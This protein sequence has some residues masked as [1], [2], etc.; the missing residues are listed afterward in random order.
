MQSWLELSYEIS[1]LILE[2]HRRWFWDVPEDWRSLQS[3]EGSWTEENLWQPAVSMQFRFS[4]N[5]W[6]SEKFGVSVRCSERVLFSHLQMWWILYP[7]GRLQGRWI[8]FALRRMFACYQNYQCCEINYCL[9]TNFL[10]LKFKLHCHFKCNLRIR[11][12][13]RKLKI[14]FLYR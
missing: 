13:I 9:L 12:Q 11:T 5:S 3:P 6:Y 4:D 2:L 7:T 14:L 1:T 10:R 8:S